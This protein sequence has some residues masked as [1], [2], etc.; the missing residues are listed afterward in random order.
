MKVTADKNSVTEL[1]PFLKKELGFDENDSK[2]T[3]SVTREKMTFENNRILGNIFFN[4][5]EYELLFRLHPFFP[6]LTMM[7]RA[8]Q[9]I[10][11]MSSFYHF[12]LISRTGN[13]SREK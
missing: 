9:S 11:E 10:T 3:F 4:K 5:I 12:T 13:A 6:L 1:L 7:V 2:M 8:L